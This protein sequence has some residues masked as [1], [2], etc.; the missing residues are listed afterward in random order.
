MSDSIWVELIDAEV[1]GVAVT[2]LTEFVASCVELRRDDTVEKKDLET[3]AVGVCETTAVLDRTP[4]SERRADN[5][6][7]G[8]GDAHCVARPEWLEASV[9]LVVDE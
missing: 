8:D 6:M 4:E 9:L 2:S 7:V 5:E 3:V 1:D